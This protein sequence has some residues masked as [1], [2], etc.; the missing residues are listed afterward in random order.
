MTRYMNMYGKN[1][2]QVS[3][4]ELLLALFSQK[5]DSNP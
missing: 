1:E 3:I 2:Q 4:K 5:R